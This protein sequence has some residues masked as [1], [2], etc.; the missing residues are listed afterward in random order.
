MAT[1][2]ENQPAY[3]LH[4]R[5]FKESSLI[6][7]IFSL[8]YGRLSIV[9]NGA[10]KSG[11]KGKNLAALLQPFQ[12]LNLSWSGRSNLKTLRSAE[13]AS[14]AFSLTSERLY[15]A[16]YLNELVLLLTAESDPIPEI[17]IQ[18]AST[19]EELCGTEHPEVSLRRFE[20]SLLKSLG[21]LPNFE[22][23]CYGNVI[24]NVAFYYLNY[25][26]GFVP[27]DSHV[28]NQTLSAK[29][30]TIQSMSKIDTAE[31]VDWDKDL[32]RD[33]KH[34]MRSLIDFSLQGREL[35]SRAMYKQLAQARF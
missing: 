29:G 28:A 31:K 9:A 32:L 24:D 30:A 10:G 35:K 6:V 8:N 11:T 22:V 3:V 27:C 18:Y 19:I 5:P 2:H 25:E 15:C 14:Q 20:F 34:I 16:Y 7:D 12:P 21:L 4:R 33:S 1:I 23:D 26:E 13:S 17:F